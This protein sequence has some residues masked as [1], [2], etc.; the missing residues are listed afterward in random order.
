M[1]PEKCNKGKVVETW[2]TGDQECNA[3][4]ER[5]KCGGVYHNNFGDVVGCRTHDCWWDCSKCRK[6]VRNK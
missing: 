2:E 3:Y 4:S 5:Y 1:N 6:K